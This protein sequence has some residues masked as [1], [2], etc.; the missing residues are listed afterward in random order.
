MGV[1]YRAII[2]R[3]RFG[4]RALQHKGVEEEVRHHGIRERGGRGVSSPEEG[5]RGGD[6]SESSAVDGSPV[7]GGG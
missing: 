5:I 2:H 1:F 6:N 3:N 4:G 7:A